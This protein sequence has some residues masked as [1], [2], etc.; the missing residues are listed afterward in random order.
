MT[1]TLA[2]LLSYLLVYKYA[3]LVVVVFASGILPVPI[4]ALMV[5]AG[6]FASQGY[7]SLSLS[8]LAV[9]VT[10]VIA[11]TVVYLIARR[12]GPRALKLFRV[13]RS[14]RIHRVKGYIRD[15]AGTTIF[16]TRFVGGLDI[17]GNIF[18]GLAGVSLPVFVTFDLLGN[19][20][21]FAFLLGLGFFFGA[22]WQSVVAEL[23]TIGWFVLAVVLVVFIASY[24]VY[25]KRNR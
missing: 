10:N 24:H 11:D 14:P 25:R 6:A 3:F 5:A 18:A 1:T 9:T 8:L 2:A 19:G 12:Y 22:Y 21:D 4:A 7:L 16:L 20:I 17:A 13:E 23:G 15:Y